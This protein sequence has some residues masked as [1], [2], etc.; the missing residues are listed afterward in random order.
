MYEDKGGVAYDSYAT[1]V[2]STAAK[3]KNPQVL[4]GKED[5]GEQRAGRTL[6]LCLCRKKN[7]SKWGENKGIGGRAGHTPPPVDD[8]AMEKKESPPGGGK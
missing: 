6:P 4:G 7:P 1:P 5:R 8:T 3:N 2:C